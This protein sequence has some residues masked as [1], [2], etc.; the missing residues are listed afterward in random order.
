MP[1]NDVESDIA[2]LESKLKASKRKTNTCL[3]RMSLIF[4]NSSSPVNGNSSV[5]NG[6]RIKN[7]S[8][9]SVN[10][11]DSDSNESTSLSLS[12]MVNDSG[13]LDI[14]NEKSKSAMRENLTTIVKLHKNLH[15]YVSKIGKSIDNLS[16]P[17][18]QKSKPQDQ[19]SKSRKVTFDR[20]DSN[21]TERTNS[22][23]V[24][25][26]SSGGGRPSSTSNVPDVIVPTTTGVS[27]E[28]SALPRRTTNRQRSQ[29]E[30]G[31]VDS[32]RDSRLRSRTSISNEFSK[33]SKD[34]L[35]L[36]NENK[37]NILD[38]SQILPFDDMDD[39][40]ENAIFYHF[41]LKNQQAALR[42]L[43]KVCVKRTNAG[44]RFFR[45]LSGSP[46]LD[47]KKELMKDEEIRRKGADDDPMSDDT[48]AP[49]MRKSPSTK[50]KLPLDENETLF[51]NIGRLYEL[52]S[53]LSALDYKN[54]LAPIFKWF[55][56][57]DHTNFSDKKLETASGK[58]S[59]EKRF[60]DNL[61]LEL[62]R[63]T[64]ALKITYYLKELRVEDGKESPFKMSTVNE[65]LA[66]L[67]YI[68]AQDSFRYELVG[69]LA[70][71][72]NLKEWPL[73]E[74]YLTQKAQNNFKKQIK[75][76]S[77]QLASIILKL[78]EDSPLEVAF[79]AGIYSIPQLVK[80]RKVL[81]QSG[82]KDFKTWTENDELPVEINLPEEFH[83]HSVLACPIQK[84]QVSR[85]NPAMM[86][87][88]KHI[89]SKEAL[90]RMVRTVGPKVNTLKCPYC[91]VEQK[92]EEAVQ[93]NF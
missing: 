29:S 67:K 78:P 54:D 92:K 87:K 12:S 11:T 34:D 17:N 89:I 5:E 2:I 66:A 74:K 86:L 26:S 39:K 72:K 45:N 44:S 13:Q 73:Y 90:N 80:S 4:E 47:E 20:S 38:I 91:P 27:P 30:R 59:I 6:G 57:I 46:I 58:I 85:S 70:Y 40:L 41:L 19:N 69:A 25:S 22:I 88:C 77:K 84:T 83:F 53:A 75:S 43:S 23:E 76:R 60:I 51:K 65:I 33:R 71:Y 24:V 48:V 63:L 42:E 9:S 68:P 28:T 8:V 36:P 52:H 18:A 61:L 10:M 56:G 1:L 37:I 21:S 14:F 55:C 32:S 62:I 35:S 82:V 16:D 49:T 31:L 7:I 81:V 64:H 50:R 79:K 93:I 3:Q 15:G